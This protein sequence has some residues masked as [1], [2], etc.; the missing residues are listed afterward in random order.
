MDEATRLMAIKAM[1]AADESWTLADPLSDA[2]AKVAALTAHGEGLTLKLQQMQ[3]HTQ[4]Q[5]DSVLTRQEKVVGD[6]R[7]QIS[8][9]EALAARELARAEQ[10]TAAQQASLQAAR[11]LTAAELAVIAQASARLQSLASQ[12]GASPQ[13]L[14]ES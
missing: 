6:I 4:S 13:P 2:A 3:V 10:E 8:E 7:K 9:L 12:F 1:D 11:D 5:L 14:Q